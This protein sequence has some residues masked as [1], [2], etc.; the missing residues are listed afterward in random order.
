MTKTIW[1]LFHRRSTL[2][3]LVAMPFIGRGLV[4]QDTAVAAH[5]AWVRVPLPSKPQTA[6][7]MELENHTGQN[8]AIVSASSDAAEKLELH[9]MK[10]DG[11]MMRM[12]PVAKV[13]VPAN[14]KASLKPGGFHIMM[15]GI[16]GTLAEGDTVHLTLKLDNGAT[17]P[18]T[19]KVR[20]PPS[21]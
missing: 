18:V 9:E 16:K 21:E 5:D 20:Q 19:A 17:V 11:K 1:T 2:T 8:R 14:G 7:F 15:F 6:I 4:A 13:D 10:T 3:L 12:S